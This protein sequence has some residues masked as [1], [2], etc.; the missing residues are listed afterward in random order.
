[1]KRHEA[2][3]PVDLTSESDYAKLFT[4]KDGR[5]LQ[6]YITVEGMEFYRTMASPSSPTKVSD[7]LEILRLDALAAIRVFIDRANAR[8]NTGMTD[9]LHLTEDF[10]EYV[11]SSWKLSAHPSLRIRALHYDGVTVDSEKTS[12]TDTFVTYVDLDEME[13]FR[14]ITWLESNPYKLL[15]MD[16]YDE[17]DK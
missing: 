4:S 3:A 1:M 2:F 14:I 15:C 12:L 8:Q 5:G 6:Q 11:S 13:L 16:L 7:R 17:D 9:V 10:T